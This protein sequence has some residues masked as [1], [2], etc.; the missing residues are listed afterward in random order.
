MLHLT[1]VAV[2]IFTTHA[3]TTS[4]SLLYTHV[5]YRLY[6][7]LQDLSWIHII[8]FFCPTVQR[9]KTVPRWRM[10]NAIVADLADLADVS[11]IAIL[12]RLRAADVA[13]QYGEGKDGRGAEFSEHQAWIPLNPIE[14]PEIG[15][16]HG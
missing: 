12:A 16:C 14:S 13:E 6:I 5:L 10:A 1:K 11:S 7:I 9:C 2:R 8:K 15:D 4:I 3:Y